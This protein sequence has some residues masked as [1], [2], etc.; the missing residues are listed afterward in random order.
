MIQKWWK[1]T[2]MHRGTYDTYGKGDKGFIG[3]RNETKE[4]GK[5][6]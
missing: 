5:H 2:S 6:F 4:H 3:R 1:V